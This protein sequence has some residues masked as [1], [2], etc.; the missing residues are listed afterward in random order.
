M[1]LL[2]GKDVY[3]L[4]RGRSLAEGDLARVAS[5]YLPL[6]GATGMGV[7]A[8]LHSAVSFSNGNRFLDSAF[9]DTGLNPDRFS[10][11]LNLLEGVGLVRTFVA[12]GEAY[13]FVVYPPLS[14]EA[15]FAHPL[16]SRKLQATLG[17]ENY[18]F[19]KLKLLPPAPEV[20]GLKEATTSFSSAFIE[21]AEAPIVLSF[22]RS[23]FLSGFEQNG[24]SAKLISDKEIEQAAY[25]AEFYSV[26]SS[27]AGQLAGEC[28]DFNAPF[29]QKLNLKRLERKY[30]EAAGY[31]F[32]T[33]KKE[34][35]SPIGNSSAQAQ[36]IAFFDSVTP[37]RFL[38]TYQ[39]GGKVSPA[40]AKLV[41][42][43]K[44]MRLPDPVINA[45]LSF[46]LNTHGNTLPPYYVTMMAGIIGRNGINTSRD[47]IEFLLDYDKKQKK[48]K[49]EKPSPSTKRKEEPP[50]E[51]TD[52][53]VSL[54]EGEAALKEIFGE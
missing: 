34:E 24:R 13:A 39:G 45:L 47:A 35:K 36:A 29:G 52:D 38:S 15:F 44:E 16:L 10:L 53:Q 8:Y 41:K 20:K 40:D 30:D 9:K 26:E 37:L 54:E 48:S 51:E 43:L 18:S 17:E 19:L 11:G 4:L 33:K 31:G 5:C 22:D 3:R 1:R 23:A 12:E 6:I 2:G 46:T 50:V 21:T 42:Q 32:L 7:Y 49:K 14:Y 27:V 25:L 28:L